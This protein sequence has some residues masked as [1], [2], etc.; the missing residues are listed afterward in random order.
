MR[1]LQKQRY[2]MYLYRMVRN[3]RNY[4]TGISILCTVLRETP[5]P[6]ALPLDALVLS[7]CSLLCSLYLST[8]ASMDAL[9]E[10][11]LK[12]RPLLICKF[13]SRSLCPHLNFT[14]RTLVMNTSFSS[15][16]IIITRGP[17]KR[18][19]ML[20]CSI[21]GTIVTQTQQ[22]LSS[23]IRYSI[24]KYQSGQQVRSHYFCMPIEVDKCVFT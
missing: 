4:T 6:G 18:W 1:S 2:Y 14:G 15:K 13:L 9:S 8:R 12:V 24:L 11:S 17:L 21:L 19:Q 10:N 5:V 22:T 16:K 23:K 20:R 7:L 3:L